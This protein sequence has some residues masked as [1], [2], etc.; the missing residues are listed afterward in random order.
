MSMYQI[1]ITL[2][3]I[4]LGFGVLWVLSLILLAIARH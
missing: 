1:G 2:Y 3:A 4:G